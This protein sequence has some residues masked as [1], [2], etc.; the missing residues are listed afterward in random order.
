MVLY[1]RFQIEKTLSVGCFLIPAPDVCHDAKNGL[2]YCWCSSGDL[3]NGGDS[4][5]QGWG[6]GLTIVKVLTKYIY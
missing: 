3:C 5:L 2:S 6:V 1:K 4:G